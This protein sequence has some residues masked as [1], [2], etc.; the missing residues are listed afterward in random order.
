MGEYRNK[1]IDLG[2]N[3]LKMLMCF[4]VL[5]AHCWDSKRYEAII[6]LPFKEIRSLAVPVFM[7]L[8]F[9]FLESFFSSPN[10]KQLKKRINKLI[11]PLIIWAVIYYI[12]YQYLDIKVSISD[13]FWQ[14]FTGHSQTLNPTMW[15]QVELI[16]L[17]L[18]F[19][20]LF[21][22]FKTN[23][24][25]IILTIL[26]I[27]CFI[28]QYSAINYQLFSNLRFELSYPLG[29]FIEMIPYAYFGLLLKHF[30]IL[31]KLKK[32]RYLNMIIATLLFFIPYNYLSFPLAKGFGYSGITPL[33]LAIMAIIVASMVPFEKLPSNIKRIIYQISR[34]TLGIYCCHRLVNV[35]LINY[36]PILPIES[37]S[38]SIY[39]YIISYLL[40]L[41]ISLIPN[42]IIKSLVE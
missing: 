13:L 1:K 14:I 39:V 8:S 6:Y 35:L 2:L 38:W 34:Y 16:L 21:K 26:T 22:Y 37:F 30:N 3:L 24:A 9:Y 42:K 19:Y 36:Y 29:R 15:F 25:Y 7:I 33:Y 32:H 18:I 10:P 4:G 31:E 40:C 17:T 41:L 5:L 27:S 12:L 11:T 28:L 20:E 23:I